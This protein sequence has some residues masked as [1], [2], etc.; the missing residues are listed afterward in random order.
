MSNLSIT[1]KISGIAF[2]P[3]SN[4]ML[5]LEQC[6]PPNSPITG[7]ALMRGA[8]QLIKKNVALQKCS[9]FS[10]FAAIV[11]VGQ[12]GLSLDVHLGQSYL[13]PIAGECQMWLGW[14]GMVELARR[15]GEIAEIVSEIRYSKDRFNIS[16]GTARNIEHVPADVP[17]SK[18][19]AILGA[20]A[21]ADRIVNG[22]LR[23][24]FEY[25]DIEQINSIKN[26][27]LKR[28][29]SDKP[30]AWET[31]ED[32]MIRKTPIRRL[33]KRL[34][35]SPAMIPLIRAA[36]RDEYRQQGL[37]P[38][39]QLPA[40]VAEALVDEGIHE[41]QPEAGKERESQVKEQSKSEQ[42][43][44]KI[45]KAQVSQIYTLAADLAL[46]STE[47]PKALREIGHKGKL[48]ELPAN[49]CMALAG[50][51]QKRAEK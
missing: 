44:D 23:P 31:N 5:A 29:K 8:L 22:N 51:L 19:G 30:G 33:A 17:V 49:L 14:R 25:M 37:D 10:L 50:N 48:D 4:F 26:V 41:P 20:Y 27:V 45:T 39:I 6:L 40:P 1:D 35:Q 24:E 11:E 43:A 13:V 32:E 34:P 15:S 47:I 18:R 21:I 38:M 42:R 2:Q 7:P 16:Y 9:E 28:K 36:I 3:K 46:E 12:S